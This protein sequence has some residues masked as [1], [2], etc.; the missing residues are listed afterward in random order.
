M[1]VD[2]P[3]IKSAVATLFETANTTTATRDLSSGLARRVQTINTFNP[4]RVRPTGNMFP[5][6]FIWT[7]GKKSNLETINLSL[8]SGKRKCEILFQIAGVVWI[9]YT[10]DYTED[11]A[12][13]DCEKLMENI[14]EILRN[15]D[16]LTQTVKWHMA[17]EIS[18]HSNNLSGEEEAHLRIGLMGLRAVVY[19]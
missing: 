15:S 16:T 13:T 5:G 18:Y 14:E 1:S 9:P 10:S 12:D 6:V 3:G 4:D 17:P 19:Y 2:I 11:P 8:A 7:Q